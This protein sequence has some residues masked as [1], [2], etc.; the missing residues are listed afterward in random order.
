MSLTQIV[1]A[2]LLFVV[3]VFVLWGERGD[4]GGQNALFVVLVGVLSGI[5]GLVLGLGG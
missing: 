5:G 4:N 3:A 2:V 1:C